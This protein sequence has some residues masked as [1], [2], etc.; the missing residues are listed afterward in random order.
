V[1]LPLERFLEGAGDIF[2]ISAGG[3]FC[4][5][6]TELDF[7]GQPVYPFFHSLFGAGYALDL[8]KGVGVGNGVVEFIL[9]LWNLTMNPVPFAGEQIGPLYLMGMPLLIF[10]RR[11]L[12]ACDVYSVCF[13]LLLT[14]FI[15]MQAQQARFFIAACPLWAIGAGVA[16]NALLDQ[17]RV[18]RGVI[19]ALVLSIWLVD[20]GIFVRRLADSWPL[21]LGKEK[22]EAYLASKERSFLGNDYLRRTLS[23]EETVCNVADTRSFYGPSLSQMLI[24]E[25]HFLSP[26]EGLSAPLSQQLP[27]EKKIPG[28]IASI[29]RAVDLL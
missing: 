12:R 14:F 18:V 29:V 22:T 23:S 28:S 11:R 3:L 9:L 21:L 15:F 16:F 1:G 20:A 27:R 8:S 26:S 25:F 17:G 24:P 6:F 2:I 19:V 13:A 7:I 5:V 10:L 4:L